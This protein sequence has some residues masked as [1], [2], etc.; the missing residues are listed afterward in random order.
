MTVSQRKSTSR[1]GSFGL[2]RNDRDTV[3]ALPNV[4]T[5][6]EF[7]PGYE[8]IL[9]H[10]N[11]PKNTPAEIVDTLNNEINAAIASPRIKARFAELGNMMLPTSPADFEKLI[12]EGTKSGARLSAQP[13]SRR[14]EPS[15]GM[16]G[17]KLR[18]LQPCS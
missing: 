2:G 4:P 9:W 3:E 10:G 7:A 15:N 11:A 18:H 13:T 14:I 16:R 8:A 17:K 6:G 12:A 5:V 1:P